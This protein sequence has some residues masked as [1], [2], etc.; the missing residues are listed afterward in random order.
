M[1]KYLRISWGHHKIDKIDF[2]QS[3][4]SLLFVYFAE[5]NQ[6]KLINRFSITKIYLLPLSIYCN[7]PKWSKC[8]IWGRIVFSF[9]SL[10][11][12]IYMDLQ[13]NA[14]YSFLIYLIGIYSNSCFTSNRRA[15]LLSKFSTW[16]TRMLLKFFTFGLSGKRNPTSSYT[17]TGIALRS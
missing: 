4:A 6:M 11:I 17:T 14:V 5:N 16:R 9:D 15:N 3:L 2:N 8:K 13:P 12:Y 10:Y 1:I 7:E